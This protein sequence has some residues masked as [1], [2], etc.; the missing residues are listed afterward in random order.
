MASSLVLGLGN[1]LSGADA[2]GPAVVARLREGPPLPGVEI[3]DAG[4]DLLD[5]IPRFAEHD[6]VV[7]VDAVA[8]DDPVDAPA[9]LPCVG[10]V[11]ESAFAGW[12]ARS[13]GAHEISPLVA[14]RLFRALRRGA[15]GHPDLP[16][17]Q[18]VALFLSDEDFS[19]R[20]READISAGVTAVR[21]LAC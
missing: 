17:I 1:R 13:P 7:L 16:R 2:F 19:L 3:A 9:A 18:L 15:S 10:T 6:R 14:V 8:V 4:T 5:W 12:D 21:Q 20:P 11:S